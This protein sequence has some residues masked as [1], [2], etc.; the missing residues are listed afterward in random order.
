M[1]GKKMTGV[2]SWKSIISIRC[3]KILFAAILTYWSVT[4]NLFAQPTSLK[5]FRHITAEHGLSQSHVKTILQ[6]SRGF[7]WF[8][9]QDGLNRYDGYRCIIYKNNP[10][11]SSTISGNFVTDILEDSQGYLWIATTE[12]LNKYDRA[13]NSFTR[14]KHN[15]NKPGS[16]SDDHIKCLLEDSRGNLWIG[17]MHGGLNK[18]D[19]HKNEFVHHQHIPS[20]AHSIS[21]NDVTSILEDAKHQMWI[22]TE[23]GGLNLFDRHTNRFMRFQHNASPKSITDN[24]VLCLLEDPL[25]RLWIGT[26]GG[27]LNLLTSANGEFRH[28]RHQPGN[29]SLAR[30]IVLSMAL[31]E[32]GKLWVGTENGGLSILDTTTEVFTNYVHDGLDN[33]SLSNNS[34]Y[35]VYRD[36]QGNM[37]L[38]TFSGGANVYN[39]RANQF[40]HYKHNSSEN[41]LT[42]NNV[43]KFLEDE[44][45]KVWIGTDGGGVDVFDPKTEN[46]THFSHQSQGQNSICGNYI[47][48]LALDPD[49]NIWMGSCGDGISI[50]DPSTRMFRLVKK[51]PG[52]Q[53]SIS[54]NNVAYME[55]D[56]DQ[57]LWI[58]SWDGGLDVFTPNTKKFRQY[59]ALEDANSR[60]NSPVTSVFT[61]SEGLIWLG[62]YDKGLDVYDKKTNTFTHFEANGDKL[63]L[64][65]NVVYCIFEDV[66]KN[67]W[68]G[69]KS[70]LNLFDKTSKT[71]KHYSTDDGLPNEHILAI[72]E[73][74]SG[75]LW[76]ST[77]KG[78]SRF[79]P[80]TGAIF[81]F[82]VADGLQS[83]EF[84]ARACLKSSSGVMYFGG[85]NGFNIFHP[86]SI[87]ANQFQSPLV[88]TNLLIFNKEV[89]V[90]RP[91][92]E[93]PLKKQISETTEL[94]LP[95]SS[96]VITFELASLSYGHREYKKYAYMLEGF[97]NQWNEV[98][99]RYTA[100]YTNLDP[101]S[102]IFKAKRVNEAGQQISKIAE[103]KL[104]IT[105]PFWMTWWF[106]ISMAL[107][108]L[109]LCVAIFTG[110]MRRIEKQKLVLK[111]E[112]L[113]RTSEVMTQKKE[114]EVQAERLQSYIEQIKTKQT[115]TERAR[116]EA[117]VAR[118]EA[119]LANNAKS[120]F[121]ATMSHEIRTPMNGV[122]GM[123]YL[124]SETPLN[125]EQR[126]Y[127]ETIRNSGESLLTII[128]DILDFSK[129]ESGKMELEESDFNLRTCIEAVLDLFALKASQ[130]DIDLVYQIEQ[131]IPSTFVGDVTR[132]KQILLNLVGNAIKFTKKG[133]ILVSVSLRKE[134]VNA[135]HVFLNFEV[136]DTGIG[137]PKEKLSKLF[138]A[139]SQVD[140]S[141]TRKFGGTGLGLVITE[142]L[143]ALMDGQISVESEV[144]QGS[145][146]K[147]T[148][149]TRISDGM[150]PPVYTAFAGLRGKHV[151][152]VD[153]NATMLKGL[154]SQLLEW[155]MAPTLA[156]SAR[157]ALDLLADGNTFDLILTGADM[158]EMNGIELAKVVQARHPELPV[159]LVSSIINQAQHEQSK[160]FAGVVSKPVKMHLLRDQLLHALKQ[161][162]DIAQKPSQTTTLSIQF[163]KDYP[164]SILLVEDNAVNQ[165]LASR[166]LLKL[167]YEKP[168]IANNGVE[169][170]QVLKEQDY[171]IVFMDVQMPEMDG[172]ETTRRIRQDLTKQPLII[173]MTANAMQGDK[174]ECLQAGMDDYISKPLKMDDLVNMIKKW[175]I[176]RKQAG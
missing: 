76:I 68:I 81:N 6:D 143:V 58:A 33:T 97:D 39:K 22:G 38:G 5:K 60:S 75:N 141:T 156:R 2:K 67:I 102:Y 161:H 122:I 139:F 9:T 30:D 85:V 126:E 130:Q 27:G 72:L 118:R 84:K 159:I 82:T 87:K 64:S 117:E 145:T 108:F 44:D 103:L 61:D 8:G 167:G 17:T 140:S 162:N 96:S 104:V 106:K 160:L 175:S 147:F 50:L 21:D 110:R 70:G 71:F 65:N 135:E 166:V 1:G 114:L 95:Y 55:L 18:F 164:L 146:F 155:Q 142:K 24:N 23:N 53:G 51:I 128:N 171:D 36:P 34:I 168:G 26:R 42:N 80:T 90:S 116:Y 59:P 129:I 88:F 134:S 20:D 174:E 7:M 120:T 115:E 94:I 73:D 111:K 99:T 78:L 125:H 131:N 12:G 105:P 45:G 11:D 127:A 172:L 158:A 163:S 132:V 109:S 37:W 16:I 133:E 43:L 29:T 124:L 48:A 41:S 138:K 77:N 148:I 107:A 52:L 165:L 152:V 10:Q 137:I 28:F 157:Q 13:S 4:A 86:D 100:T 92:F 150:E 83:N 31:D 25:Q 119:E 40:H 91:G 69:T 56:H 101:G 46:F 89:P 98:G 113:E 57:E 79:N 66:R 32:S 93:T 14:Y 121:L 3:F 169:A 149:K 154:Q 47:P 62:T 112:V 144:G 153:D 19:N 170:L 54:G 35:D 123:A 15:K 63:S 173:A 49:K 176:Q 151:L 74:D 136:R